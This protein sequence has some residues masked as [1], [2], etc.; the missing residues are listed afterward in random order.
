MPVRPV[1]W[2]GVFGLTRTPPANASDACG[3]V[4]WPRRFAVHATTASDR[5]KTRVD[6]SDV[7]AV[8]ARN[9]PTGSD[10]V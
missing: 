3:S 9:Q 6:S 2:S 4:D 7:V 10:L 5:G 8:T 1:I